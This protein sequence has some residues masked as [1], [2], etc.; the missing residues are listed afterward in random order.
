VR[1]VALIGQIVACPRCN[2]MVEVIAPATLVAAP[3]ETAPAMMDDLPAQTSELGDALSAAEAAETANGAIA[4]ATVSVARY[5]FIAWSLA[6]VAVV[7]TAVAVVLLSRGDSTAEVTTPAEA[8]PNQV[9]MKLPTEITAPIENLVA[10]ANESAEATVETLPVVAVEKA[11]RP[12]PAVEQVTVASSAPELGEVALPATQADAEP[13]PRPPRS[14]DPL[15]FDPETLSLAALD[16]QPEPVFQESDPPQPTASIE[17]IAP[18]L[19]AT[20]RRGPDRDIT[21]SERNAKKQLAIQ[22][23]ALQVDQL[24]L[25]DCCHLFS[26]LSGVPVSVAPE[27][28]LMAA[29]T[30]R[31]KVSFSASDVSLETMLR[32]L[33]EPLRL[34]VV[35]RGPQVV[36]M[37][38]A[39]T[40]IREVTYPIDDLVTEAT[41]AD[42]LAG[43]VKQL[44]APTTWL[45]V[46]GQGTLE[47]AA[48]SLRI[49]QTQQV[50]Y[51][52]LIFLERLR[53][54]RSLPV[55]SR[56]PVQRLA[57]QPTNLVLR[58]NLTTTTT[59][60]FSRL[61]ALDEVFIHWQTELG[62]PLLIDWPALAELEFWPESTIACA[63]NN[64]PWSRALERVLEPLGLG[65]R[66]VTGGA[67]EI[68]SAKKVHSEL[69]LEIYPLRGDLDSAAQQIINRI[70]ALP[71]GPPAQAAILIDPV[72]KVLLS[73]Q[74]AVT[75]LAVFRQ[76]ERQ[77]FLRVN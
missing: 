47:T 8:E 17:P 23:P 13:A 55:K 44:I 45:S 59:F 12:Q 29:I 36:V 77:Q 2:S 21:T 5:K 32:E 15:D 43:W 37:R 57:G 9:E 68:T 40:K 53:L 24:S 54:A 52:I 11:K 76:L 41:G 69:Q 10:A 27:Q 75:Q 62:V 22:V 64:E 35:T 28:L 1:N 31:K 26:Q 58:N 19:S 63:I 7:A 73:Y 4:Q 66:A 51:Q 25:G 46:G 60:N 34:E 50:Q 48:S 16:R 72:G 20:V 3:S 65:W 30:P 71:Q 74:P 33:L 67:I 18:S 49:K 42:E 39:A 61:T 70:A 56:Y 6:S 14:F 38:K